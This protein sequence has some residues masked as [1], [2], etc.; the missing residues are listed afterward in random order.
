MQ[1]QHEAFLT[2]TQQ[3][4]RIIRHTIWRVCGEKYP[5]LQADIEQE[6]SLTLWARWTDDHCIDYPVSYLYKVALRTA[7]AV[8]RTYTAAE[9]VDD[10]EVCAG[11][12]RDRPEDDALTTDCALMLSVCLDQLS[13]EQGRAVRAYLA[14]FTQR[15]IAALYGWS[16]S[17]AR[18]R[19][20]RGL[21]ALRSCARQEVG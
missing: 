7:L 1:T 21:Q 17:V 13:V 20:Y 15:E 3:Y 2:F 18:H 8:L 19:I 16:V 12:H 11:T 14:G 6:V 4:A 10:V 9:L 5:A